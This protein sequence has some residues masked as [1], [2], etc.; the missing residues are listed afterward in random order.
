M[1]RFLSKLIWMLFI[2]VGLSL[3]IYTVFSSN[4]ENN[5]EG[6]TPWE[7]N[8]L[9]YKELHKL[10]TGQSQ[11][12]AI[13]DSGINPLYSGNLKFKKSLVDQRIE[14]TNGHGTMMY[15]IIKGIN[16][17]IEGISPN[18]QIIVIKVMNK[19]DS[20]TP[21]I[22]K[23]AIELAIQK[24]ASIINLSIASNFEDKDITGTIKLAVKKGITVVA[25]SGDY[26]NTELMYPAILDEVISVGA[27]DV[28]GNVLDLTSGSQKTTINAPGHEIST[29]D[30]SEIITKTSGTSQATALI[31]GYIALLKDYAFS[32]NKELT[33][34][35][36]ISL[37]ESINSQE[38]TY[39]Q[40]MKKIDS[41]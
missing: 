36:I 20:V 1:K 27:I 29:I 25:S 13:I 23:D 39:L 32:K 33:N 12:I 5:S 24:N 4:Y 18:A 28:S 41:F 26:G 11:T 16:G 38:L 6:D 37:L 31:S 22:I 14:D 34:A 8:W 2:F 30:T 19:D 7:I 40:A 15:S 21:T 10:S 9:D 35:S 3:T 17:E